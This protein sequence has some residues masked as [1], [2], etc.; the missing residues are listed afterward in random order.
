MNNQFQCFSGICI[1]TAWVCDGGNDCTTGEDEVNCENHRN[2]TEDQFKC[3]IDGSCVALSAVCNKKYDC[4]DG[5]DEFCNDNHP[6]SPGGTVSCST[7]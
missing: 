3:K 5:S 1:P 4:P 2:C 6:H 7:G